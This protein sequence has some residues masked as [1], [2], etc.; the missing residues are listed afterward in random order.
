VTNNA[1]P[2]E[3]L[4]SPESAP[5]SVTSGHQSVSFTIPAAP[6]D[7]PF[8]NFANVYVT[9]AATGTET[10]LGM[11][12]LNP[13]APTTVTYNTPIAGDGVTHPPLTSMIGHH[14]A[15]ESANN[16]T[17]NGC[18]CNTVPNLS[19]DPRFLIVTGT[20]YQISAKQLRLIQQLSP[21]P[22]FWIE[23]DAAPPFGGSASSQIWIESG[24]ITA[25]QVSIGSGV[26]GVTLNLSGV[27][28]LPNL[29]VASGNAPASGSSSGTQGNI[30]WDSGFIY[31]ATGTNT[32]KRAALSSF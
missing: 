4:P 6:T 18:T 32:W 24:D 8:I 14:Y 3:S 31:V 30:A 27:L 29:N 9:N 25:S 19:T 21:N 20:S 26:T 10:F 13:G 17:L 28:Q 1:T 22:A 15:I 11:I 23:L 5:V 7:V 12:G 2:L 16:I